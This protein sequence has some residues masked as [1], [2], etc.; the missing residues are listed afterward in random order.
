[1]TLPPKQSYTETINGIP[2][3]MIFIEGGKVIIEGTAITV[4]DFYL[5]ET[6]CTQALW[7]AVMGKDPDKLYFK[8]D[9]RPVER[10][11]WLD[12]VEGTDQTNGKSFLDELNKKSK[13]GDYKLPSEAMWQFVAQ[14][15][16]QSNGFEYAGSNNLK[17]VGWY[18]KNSHGETKPVKLKFPNE[19]DLFDMSG[20][21]YEWSADGKNLLISGLPNDQGDTKRRS[22]RGGSWDFIDSYCRTALRLRND[23]DFR[24]VNTGF[25]IARY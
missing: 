7:R 25:R 19:L 21:V 24:I 20:N 16:N 23:S 6:P 17:E 3:K 8:G 2:F 4:P 1:M 11:S 15:G 13:Y 22:V 14:G 9:D 18:N 12:I 5:A 10:V